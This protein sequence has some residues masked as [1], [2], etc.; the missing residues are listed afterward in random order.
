MFTPQPGRRY[1][2]PAVFGSPEM[3]GQIK[4]REI[5]DIAHSF[6]S[7]PAALEALVP[8]HFSV[9]DSAKV[10]VSSSM[11]LGVDWLGG[12]DYNVARVMVEVETDYAGERVRAPYHLVLWETDPHPVIAGREFQGYAKIPGEIP[13][14]ELGDETAAFECFEYGNRLLRVDVSDVTPVIDEVGKAGEWIS[15]GWKYIPGPGGAIDADYPTRLVGYSEVL[16]MSTGVSTLSFDSPTWELCPFSAR[17]VETLA[18]L[19]VLEVAPAVVKT[20]TGVLYR[21]AVERIG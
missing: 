2:M 21:D 3:A 1:D 13:D 12:R 9:A 18:A 14:H 6:R 10:T 5:R 20:T 16:A 15:F 4:F 17:I 7:D 19:P 8:Y 11:N